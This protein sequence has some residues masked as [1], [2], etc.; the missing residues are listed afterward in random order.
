MRVPIR[1]LRPLQD[2]KSEGKP[3]IYSVELAVYNRPSF[4]ETTTG[5]KRWVLRGKD[6]LFPVYLI[7]LYNQSNTHG[8]VVDGKISYGIGRGL[9]ANPDK[10][11]LMEVAK[12]LQFLKR[13]N[14][15]ESWDALIKKTWTNF[16]IHNAYAFEILRNKQGKPLEVYNIDVDRIC[17]DKNDSSIYLYS[18]EWESQYSTPENRQQNFNPVVLE[19]PKYDPKQL[20]ERC[21]MVHYE[22]RPGMKHYTLPPYINGIEAIEEEIEISQFHLNNVKNGFVGGTMINFLN[23]EPQDEEKAKVEAT[24]NAKFTGGKGAKIVYNFADGKERAAEVLPLQPN[25]LD[26]QFEARAKQVPENIIIGHRAVSGMLFGIKTEGQLGGRTEILEA[27][28]LFKETYVKPRQDTVL[29]TVNKIFEIFGYAPIIEI[30]ELKPLANILPLTETTIAQIVPKQVLLDYIGEMYGLTIADVV[31]A[32]APAVPPVQFSDQKPFYFSTVGVNAADYD[33]IE[34]HF[35]EFDEQNNPKFKYDEA[36]FIEF[37]DKEDPKTATSGG[38]LP[39]NAPSKPKV[40]PLVIKY[41][42]AERPDAP[43][44]IGESRDYCKDMMALADEGKLYSKFEIENNPDIRQNNMDNFDIIN[45]SNAWLYRGGWYR[46]PNSEVTVPFCRHIWQQVL[47]REKGIGLSFGGPGSGPNEGDREGSDYGSADSSNTKSVIDK[48]ENSGENLSYK[49]LKTLYESD[50]VA[51]KVITKIDN[52][53]TNPDFSSEEIK[54]FN[55]LTTAKNYPLYRGDNRYTLANTK[56][57][58]VL[59]FSNKPTFTSSEKSHAGS[60]SKTDAIV[61]FM[62]GTSS[63]RRQWDTAEKGELVNGRYKVHEISGNTI[64]VKRI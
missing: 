51:Y 60:F 43:A 5:G 62:P 28:E 12:C 29:A 48:L 47:V 53:F 55:E 50:P 59:D 8:A 52:N 20:H 26:K 4:S 19:I 41:R 61:E 17:E 27:Y 32:P 25:T 37:A 34:S 35:I 21:I 39:K 31:I 56:S 38:N 54:K 13:P 2:D 46:S 23:G 33:E 18:L 49:D 11:G 16:E 44:L 9:F 58:D 15:Y 64:R 14:P 6:N 10:A 1:K 22:P 45:N 63:L 30:K 57:G 24:F 36:T 3:N 40:S 7:D 42:Y